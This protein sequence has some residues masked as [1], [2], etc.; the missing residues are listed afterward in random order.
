MSVTCTCGTVAD[1]DDIDCS[2]CGRE[3]T[4]LRAD[5]A[6]PVPGS[7]APH[8]TEVF[9]RP[10]GSISGLSKHEHN[11]QDHSQ[12]DHSYADLPYSG[13]QTWGPGY[14]W[15]PPQTEPAA[16]ARVATTYS[17]GAVAGIVMAALAIVIAGLALGYFVIAGFLPD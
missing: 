17:G 1:D 9:H 16:P 12:H 5:A 13:D 10:D 2:L 15:A 7:N 4:R 6:S 8:Q 14:A 11:H 3:L